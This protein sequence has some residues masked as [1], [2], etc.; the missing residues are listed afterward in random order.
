[1]KK[2]IMPVMIS[3]TSFERLNSE[4]I[5]TAPFCKNTSKAEI[6]TIVSVLNFASHATIIAMKP[7]PPAVAVEIV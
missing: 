7:R 5:A 2:S 6:K 1:M 3:E 4:A